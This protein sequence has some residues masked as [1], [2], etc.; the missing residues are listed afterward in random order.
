MDAT[1]VLHE[2][3]GWGYY[4]LPRAHLHSPGYTGLRIAIRGT[5]TKLHFDPES[6]RL[7]LRDEPGSANWTT[8][9][10]GSP[11]QVTGHVCPGRVIV[12]D[13]LDKRIHFFTF[14]GSLE[15]AFAPGVI[16]Y[17]LHSPAPILELTEPEESIPDQLASETEAMMGEVQARWGSNDAGFA[18]RLAQLDP[19]QFYLASLRSILLRYGQSRA[20]RESFEALYDALLG[21]E[22]WLMQTGQW[23]AQPL[24]LEELL[25]PD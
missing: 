4:L 3:E 23:P 1:R 9:E 19:F 17:S 10:L 20:L 15:V 5:P 16:V 25:A 6:I 2:M 14:G 8:L 21:E 7:R 22:R 24:M 18:R 11:D 12:R 13:R